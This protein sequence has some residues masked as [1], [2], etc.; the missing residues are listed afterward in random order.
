MLI[1]TE[2]L[3][4]LGSAITT[5]L[6][7]PSIGIVL[8]SSTSLLTN[9]AI[10][11]TKEYII[12]LKLPSTKQKDWIKF[13]TILYEK[14]LKQSMLDKKIDQKEAEQLKPIY[15]H[16][17]DKRKEIMNSTKYKIEDKFSGVISKDSLPTQITKL[18]L[19]FAKLM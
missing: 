10:L 18:N 3:L 4:G 1:I 8:T 12:K 13:I 17:I 5:S 16:Y 6:I 7:N 2:R 9:I 19:F 15:N 14:T 11:I